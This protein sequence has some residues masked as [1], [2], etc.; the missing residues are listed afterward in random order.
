MCT[1]A[2]KAASM[3]KKQKASATRRREAH[4]IKKVEVVHHHLKVVVRNQYMFLRNL[5]NR[6]VKWV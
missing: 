2:S 4:R 1:I 5:R 3:T 6:K